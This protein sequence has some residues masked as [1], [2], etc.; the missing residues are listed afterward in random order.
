MQSDYQYWPAFPLEQS[1]F[2]DFTLKPSRPVYVITEI[3]VKN[4]EA[5]G[6]EYAPKA[7]ASIG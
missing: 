2:K 4:P 3:D 6:K 5:F 7:Q 1:Q